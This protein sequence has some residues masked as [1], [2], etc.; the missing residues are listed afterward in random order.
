M[1]HQGCHDC[2]PKGWRGVPKVTGDYD[3]D[4]TIG[5]S[6]NRDMA[7]KLSLYVTRNAYGPRTAYDPYGSGDD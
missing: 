2:A 6:P 3:L 5:H 1:G 7:G 4:A